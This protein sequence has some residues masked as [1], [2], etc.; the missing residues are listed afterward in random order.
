MAAQQTNVAGQRGTGL[1]FATL[2]YRVEYERVVREL[3]ELRGELY[4]WRSFATDS[5]LLADRALNRIVTLETELAA[6]KAQFDPPAD[7]E[8]AA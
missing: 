6:L 4:W 8:E 1:T 2:D 3:L 5:R 7:L